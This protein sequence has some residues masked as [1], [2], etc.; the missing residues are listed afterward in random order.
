MI[1]LVMFAKLFRKLFRWAEGCPCHVHL[2]A[3]DSD[4]ESELLACY[5]EVDEEVLEDNL[6]M[7]PK[8]RALW[9]SCPMRSR[10]LPEIAAGDFLPM[11][12]SLLRV[13]LGQVRAEL[14]AADLSADAMGA[15]L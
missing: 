4:G 15:P 13:T 2:F 1:V 7:I 10:R 11:L 5:A 14:D 6:A 8:F 3:D 9:K 12:D